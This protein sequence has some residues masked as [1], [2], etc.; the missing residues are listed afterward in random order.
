MVSLAKLL[1]SGSLI[2]CFW[3]AETVLV[4]NTTLVSRNGAM[5][6]YAFHIQ[7]LPV[8]RTAALRLL[9]THAQCDTTGFPL[10]KISAL[11]DDV[12]LTKGFDACTD[13][14]ARTED[15]N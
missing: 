13:V 4:L 8:F 5:S 3:D 2:E 11:L 10:A 12:S 15:V 14:D 1:Q 7:H 9:E 6:M